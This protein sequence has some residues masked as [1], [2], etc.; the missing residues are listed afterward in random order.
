MEISYQILQ[1][2]AALNRSGGLHCKS[3]L[4]FEN[5]YFDEQGFL[6]LQEMTHVFFDQYKLKE[7]DL[8]F[9]PPEALSCGKLSERGDVWTLG[10]LLFL[11]MSLEFD[12]QSAQFDLKS[13]L[14]TFQSVKGAS[15]LTM[16]NSKNE[17]SANGS[18][19]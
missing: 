3:Q 19:H 6:K 14:E 2:F 12:L 13:M 18:R 10:M 17:R 11:C 8:V 1:A 9:M 15:L 4:H 16:A 7:S 5:I